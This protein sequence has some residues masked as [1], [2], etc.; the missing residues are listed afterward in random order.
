M[1]VD[2]LRVSLKALLWR[3]VGIERSGV[4]L[5]GALAAVTGWEG[6]ALRTGTDRIDRLSLLNMLL[7]ARLLAQS[8][9]QREESRGTHFRRDFPER[10]DACWRIHLVHRRGRE[11]ERVPAAPQG[12]EDLAASSRGGRAGAGSE[13]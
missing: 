9:L 5:T 2:D 4:H 11:V 13:G 7:V 10:D 6:F 8:A 12:L 1:D 3:E